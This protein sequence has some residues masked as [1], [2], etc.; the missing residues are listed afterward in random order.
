MFYL[1]LYYANP[2]RKM[3]ILPLFPTTIYTKSFLFLIVVMHVDTIKT[4]V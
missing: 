3:R 2:L 4:G 1:I